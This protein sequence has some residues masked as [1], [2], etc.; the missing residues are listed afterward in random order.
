MASSMN[1]HGGAFA[2]L[3]KDGKPLV[4]FV[5]GKY[6][7]LG[8]DGFP[9]YNGITFNIKEAQKWAIRLWKMGVLVFTP[10]FNTHHFEAKTRI[11]PDPHEN[12]EY[13]RAF[14]RKLI[15]KL[16]DFCYATPNTPD[17]T[18]GRLEVQ[19]C[20]HL[21]TPVLPS[22]RD[23]KLYAE[24]APVMGL[25]FDAISE[26]AKHFGEGKDLPIAMV[27][28]PHFSRDEN[29]IDAELVQHFEDLAE[30]AAKQ[31]FNNKVG[32]FTPHLNGSY[33]NLGYR[34]PETS[35]QLL[36]RE[37][38]VRRAADC[39]FL[40]K[41]WRKDARVRERVLMAESMDPI[42]PAFEHL[43]ELLSWKDGRGGARVTLK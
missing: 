6:F 32:A 1:S 5:V 15:L 39:I 34:V 21:G 14:D 17:S 31:L 42:I 3:K 16:V 23:V 7:A 11:D 2:L 8:A 30:E 4:A 43:E 20:N 9:D 10:H 13:Y 12:E 38:L 36:N 28:G 26:D 37:M 41:D 27:D 33:H 40:I 24:G 35:Y 19:L 25:R 18:G 22:V 29:E